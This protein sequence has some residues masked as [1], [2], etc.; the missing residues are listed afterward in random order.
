MMPKS[1]NIAASIT[2]Y[3]GLE[4]T[5]SLRLA[6]NRT[7]NGENVPSACWAGEL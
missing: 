4:G 6:R 3:K 2:S 7:D 1:V 5:R